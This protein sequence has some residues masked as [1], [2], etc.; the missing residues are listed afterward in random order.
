MSFD[1]PSRDE[2]KLIAETKDT[3]VLQLLLAKLENLQYQVSREKDYPQEF[4]TISN[5]IDSS[6]K[7]LL[8][9]AAKY[10]TDTFKP[11]YR[12]DIFKLNKL[13]ERF[14]LVYEE[15]ELASSYCNS[16]L[17]VATDTV[18]RAIDAIE[19]FKAIENEC[20]NLLGK[21]SDLQEKLESQQAKV[22]LLCMSV[23]D[24]LSKY[25]FSV[26]P[27]NKARMYY[28]ELRSD[29]KALAY[30]YSQGYSGQVIEAVSDSVAG[31][32][33]WLWAGSAAVGSEQNQV[34]PSS[35]TISEPPPLIPA[36]TPDEN[37][38]KDQS[39]PSRHFF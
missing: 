13:K 11:D 29:V 26:E 25:K 22:L 8:D 7:Y 10:T 38:K 18:Q 2:F 21:T 17:Y 5:D 6:I 15:A 32:T 12:N 28:K 31:L 30:Q 9:Y 33:S 39:C 23:F 34:A 37:D 27:K 3:R 16:N 35:P 24:D 36:S 1:F 19:R 20:K 4:R 14:I